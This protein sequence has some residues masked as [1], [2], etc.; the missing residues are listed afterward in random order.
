MLNPKRPGYD[1]LT[2]DEVSSFR[3]TVMHLLS[4]VRDF[5]QLDLSKL[6][7]EDELHSIYAIEFLIQRVDSI[8]LGYRKKIE[9]LESI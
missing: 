8:L 9:L 5:V 2:K 1:D 4:Y 6:P 7:T 3:K